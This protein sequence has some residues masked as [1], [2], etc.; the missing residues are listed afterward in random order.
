MNGMLNIMT[1]FSFLANEHGSTCAASTGCAEPVK[2]APPLTATSIETEPNT[3]KTTGP[4]P[5]TQ[6]ALAC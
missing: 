2:F 4:F 3:T 1:C 5:L 6:N